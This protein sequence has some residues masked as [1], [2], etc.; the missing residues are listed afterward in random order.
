MLL[1]QLLHQPPTASNFLFWDPFS[2]QNPE[3]L[4][5]EVI[6]LAN[7][8]VDGA[9]YIIFGINKGAMEGSGVVGI[10]EN[11]IADLKKAHQLISALVKPVLQLAFIFDKI[12]GKL[13]GAL[14]IDGCDTAPYVT[15]EGSSSKLAGG[16]AW[17]REGSQIRTID[18]NEL[19]QIAARTARKQTWDVKFGFGEQLYAKQLE[20][21]IPDRSKPPS[22]QAKQEIRQAIDWKKRVRDTLG[23]INT[24]ILRVMHVREHG[25][26]AEFDPRGMDTLI[27][28]QKQIGDEFAEADKYYF[29]EEKAIQLNLAVCNISE[30]KID[31]VSI[32]FTFP[33]TQDFDV[34]DRLYVSPDDKRSRHEVDMVDY[35]EVQYREKSIMVRT[36]LDYLPQERPEQV[37][38][39]ALRLAVGP[40]MR[41]KRIAINYTLRAKNMQSPTQGRLKIHFS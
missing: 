16:Q 3:Q 37:F 14:E 39:T 28:I 22:I 40:K 2:E 33:R 26:E 20:L 34:V 24:R 35:P 6:G 38:A 5:Q 36:S 41:G 15:K 29:F 4:V 10:A 23:T 12:D 7:A 18:S 27:N 1:K 19:E 13:I 30:K 25:I 32:E 21:K 11:A 17:I 31:G 9:R 8:D